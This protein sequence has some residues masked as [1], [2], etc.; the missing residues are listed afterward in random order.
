MCE[1]D[2]YST[3]ELPQNPNLLRAVEPHQLRAGLI[4]LYP[5]IRTY[6]TPAVLVQYVG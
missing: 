5:R 6:C 4:V 2:G 1:Y 3:T